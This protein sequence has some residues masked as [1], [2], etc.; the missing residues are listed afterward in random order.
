MIIVAAYWLGLHQEV[1][2]LLKGHVNT[3]YSQALSDCTN[4]HREAFE[5]KEHVDLCASSGGVS[6]TSERLQ[7]SPPRPSPH[8]VSLSLSA[9]ALPRPSAPV[10]LPPAGARNASPW[11][12]TTRWQW[13]AQ[14]APAPAGLSWCTACRGRGDSAP[15]AAACRVPRPG[16]GP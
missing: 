15:E 3:L 12:G 6:H 9:L 13:T 5:R 2:F 8:G 10:R 1:A 11:H 16:R 4:S 7:S 14:R